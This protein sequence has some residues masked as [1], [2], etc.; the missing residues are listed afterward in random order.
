MN[1]ELIFMIYFLF[2]I[3]PCHY[4]TYT[5][6]LRPIKKSLK[7][8]D[9]ETDTDTSESSE[10]SETSDSSDSSE[11]ADSSD[12]SESHQNRTTVA[13]SRPTF[14]VREMTMKM[15]MTAK[16]KGKST[17]MKLVTVSKCNI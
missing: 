15:M 5:I 8:S 13:M 16:M 14:K 1:Y 3:E 7:T 11:S 4:Q 6:Y 12:S 17:A 10:S 2:H 9:T